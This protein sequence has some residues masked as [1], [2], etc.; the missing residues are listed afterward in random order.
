[1]AAT[2]HLGYEIM[3]GLHGIYPTYQYI[4]W[5]SELDPLWHTRHEFDPGRPRQTHA[6]MRPCGF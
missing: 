4:R 5:G 3:A 2:D 6:H 1:M